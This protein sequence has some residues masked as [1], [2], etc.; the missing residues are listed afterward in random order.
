MR[1]TWYRLWLVT[2]RK[3]YT[4]TSTASIVDIHH[5]EILPKNE[6][7]MLFCGLMVPALVHQKCV[8]I[9]HKTAQQMGSKSL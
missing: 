4:V 1:P 3:L 6:N 7:K 8:Q 5:A 9:Y 2:C